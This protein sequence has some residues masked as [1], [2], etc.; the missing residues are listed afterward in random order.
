MSLDKL[1][2]A[3]Y[4]TTL[5]LPNVGG[6]FSVIYKITNL[7]NGSYLHYVMREVPQ[8]S[9][10]R[11]I[12]TSLL[13]DYSK[14]SNLKDFDSDNDILLYEEEILKIEYLG[15][16]LPHIFDDRQI[17]DLKEKVLLS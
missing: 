3:E 11:E 13:V 16:M 17:N 10:L 7:K 8:T 2:R 4:Q 6:K 9:N 12:I 1:V 15:T 5:G 14:Y